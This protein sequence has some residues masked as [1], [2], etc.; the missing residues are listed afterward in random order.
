MPLTERGKTQA[1]QLGAQLHCLRVDVAVA[2]RFLRT[3]QTAELALDGRDVPLMIEP[4]FD[5]VRAGTY[6]GAPVDT[7]WAWEEQHPTSQRLPQGESVDEAF[8]RIADG[9]QRLLSRTEPVTLVVLHSFALHSI[10]S[11]AGSSRLPGEALFA[12]A[13][14]Y[15][16]HE[17][18]VAR[19]GA[20]L[21][22]IGR[23]RQKVN[24]R[25]RRRFR[26]IPRPIGHVALLQRVPASRR[27]GRGLPQLHR[28]H[29]R[30]RMTAPARRGLPPQPG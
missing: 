28:H 22:A 17:D 1:R 9:L 3:Q 14:P 12:N 27:L 26:R 2:T 30:L 23:G 19:A 7:Y 21:E 4:H 25:R 6:D 16:F 5:E 10:A 8:L 15:L 24:L 20:G 29:S 11:A 13:V 18:A